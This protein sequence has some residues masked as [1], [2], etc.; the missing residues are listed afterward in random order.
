MPAGEIAVSSDT[1]SES[2]RDVVNGADKYLQSLS[3]L[4]SSELKKNLYVENTSMCSCCL[5]SSCSTEV[6]F[7]GRVERFAEDTDAYFP[8][9]SDLSR[10][11]YLE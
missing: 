2:W 9:L 4:V 11:S 8:F 7:F 10:A 3:T 5:N 6:L 1:P